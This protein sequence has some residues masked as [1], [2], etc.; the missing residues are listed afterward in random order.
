MFSPFIPLWLIAC[1]WL[2]D[3]FV[4]S[5]YHEI[6]LFSII[7]FESLIIPTKEGEGKK[8]IQ[9]KRNAKEVS[10]FILGLGQQ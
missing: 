7:A 10:G 8:D 3:V 1:A 4:Y 6:C 9:D 5:Q 2:A